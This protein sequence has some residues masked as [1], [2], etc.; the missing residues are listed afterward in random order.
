LAKE[1]QKVEKDGE[2][3]T[4]ERPI[5]DDTEI[6]GAIK[7]VHVEIGS[8]I[9]NKAIAMPRIAGKIHEECNKH[10]RRFPRDIYDK[11]IH[12]LDQ[13]KKMPDLVKMDDM[14]YE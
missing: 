5:L 12:Y 6:F 2:L 11:Y 13:I 14:E 7:K 4:D 1:P 9:E 8:Q 3:K 10:D